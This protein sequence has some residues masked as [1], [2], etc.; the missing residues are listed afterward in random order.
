VTDPVV[1]I[2]DDNDDNRFTLSMRLEACGYENIVTAENGHE[3]LEK[4]RSAPVDLVLLDIMMPEMNGYEVLEHLKADAE[5]RDL[6]VIVISALDEMDSVIKCIEL[7]AEDYPPSLSTRHCCG[8]GSVPAWKR[9]GCATRCGPAAT[10]CNRNSMRPGP[11]SSACC[12]APFRRGPRN[13]RSR[14]ML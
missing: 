7:G 2:V 9:S 14:S 1:L 12:R 8:R 3:A 4:M 5:L 13:T 11:S 10:A 6:P